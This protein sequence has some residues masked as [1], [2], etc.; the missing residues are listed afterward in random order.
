MK[1]KQNLPAKLAL[2]LLVVPVGGCYSYTAVRSPQAG[3]EVRARLKGDA[4][5][6]RS[7]GLDEPI[8]RFDGLVVG[9]TTEAVSLDVLVARSS[10]AF[11][12]VVIR[13]TVT[14]QL[15]E[16]QSLQRRVLSV[17]RTALFVVAAG[18]AAF[19]AI[20]GIKEVVG[21]T[22]DPDDPGNPTFTSPLFSWQTLRLLF[23][24][25][26]HR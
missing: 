10:N 7:E 25:R 2:L 9:A 24:A 20:T 3:M 13:D 26:G 17:P 11:Q 12:D 18:A 14:L 5:A 4:A 1:Q 23:A 15:A 6:K 16:I 8:I 21:G 19:G 22:E